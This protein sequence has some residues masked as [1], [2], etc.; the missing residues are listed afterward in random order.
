LKA[1][2]VIREFQ[3]PACASDEI[4]LLVQLLMEGERDWGA[5]GD[6]MNVTQT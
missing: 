1:P 5:I 4:S 6:C 3:E 2:S